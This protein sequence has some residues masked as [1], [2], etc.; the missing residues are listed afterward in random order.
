MVVVRFVLLAMLALVSACANQAPPPPAPIS[1]EQFAA[2]RIANV[3]VDTS[4]A[5]II[6]PEAERDF[7]ATKG[8]KQTSKSSAFGGRDAEQ[9]SDEDRAAFA[10]YDDAIK[11][12]EALAYYR[13]RVAGVMTPYLTQALSL[14]SQ[15]RPRWMSQLI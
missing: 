3:T 12:E 4:D 6:W 8:L 15:A 11:S 2:Y 1:A 13:Q 7:A 5:N 9:A 10:A 14:H